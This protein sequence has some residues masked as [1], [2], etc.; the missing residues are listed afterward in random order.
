MVIGAIG[1]EANVDSR[2]FN[3]AVADALDR[4]AAIEAEERSDG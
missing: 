4:L 3:R 2:G 1:P